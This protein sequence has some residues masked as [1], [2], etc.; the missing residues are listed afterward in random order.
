M[1]LYKV[2][3]KAISNIAVP[4]HCYICCVSGLSRVLS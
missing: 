2:V 3:A 4:L 1:K